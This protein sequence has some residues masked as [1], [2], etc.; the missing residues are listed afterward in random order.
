MHSECV[1]DII[2]YSKW[3]RDCLNCVCERETV[4]VCVV[5]VCLTGWLIYIVCVGSTERCSFKWSPMSLQPSH[6][7]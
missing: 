6:M 3:V 7:S 1:M 4:C 5:C 2:E